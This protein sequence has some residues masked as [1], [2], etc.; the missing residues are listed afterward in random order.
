VAPIRG[1]WDISTYLNAF[2][3]CAGFALCVSGAFHLLTK[4]QLEQ[5]LVWIPG[6]EYGTIKYFHWAVRLV[7][8]GGKNRMMVQFMSGRTRSVS[9]RM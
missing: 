4:P 1:L 8:I 6:L 3:N 9:L 7:G 5:A 2:T